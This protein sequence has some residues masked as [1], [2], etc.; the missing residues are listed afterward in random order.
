MR[1]GRRETYKGIFRPRNPQK[2]SGDPSNIVYRSSWECK[3]MSYIDSNPDIISWSSEEVIVPYK[4]P[5]DGRWHRYFPDFVIKVK[6]KT[7]QQIVTL[8]VE[9]KP[10][11]QSKPPQPKQRKTKQYI[12]EVV[13]WGVNQAKWKAA[14]EY[15]RD[16]KWQFMVMT[17]IDGVEFKYL[18]EKELLLN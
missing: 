11:R 8:M 2:Y 5:V 15:C 14:I 1:T 18:T 3:V 12:H 16:R 7:T 6:Q 9:V 4:S 10:E 13:T 17:S